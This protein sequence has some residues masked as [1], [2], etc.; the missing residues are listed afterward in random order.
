MYQYPI[1]RASALQ[2]F[3]AIVGVATTTAILLLLRQQLNTPVVALLYMLPVLG[4]TVR[5][6]L[7]SGIIA[8]AC[9]FLAF[10]FFFLSPYHT[11]VV[12]QGQDVIV[13]FVFLLIAIVIS[14]LVGRVK[15]SLAHAQAREQEVIQ[16]YK[17]SVELSGA[18][19]PEEVGKILASHLQDI[20]APANIQ[21][22]LNSIGE[23]QSVDIRQ[24]DGTP[25][26]H[27]PDC[28]AALVSRRGRLGEIRL[29]KG[30]G[31]F[32]EAE[33]R[34]LHVL[35]GQGTLALERV[36]LAEIE[37]RAIIL[38][39][40]DHLKSALL[41]SVSHE[42]RTPL[43]TIKAAATSLRSGT[44][45]WNTEARDD[46]LAALEEEADRLNQFV[47]ELLNMSRIEVGALKLQRQWNILAEIVDTSVMQMRT[48]LCEHQL[49]I[50][51]SEDLPLIPI[52][53][54]LLQQV[55]TNLL[56]N[57]LKYAPTNTLIRLTAHTQHASSMLIQIT[58]QGPPVQPEHLDHIFDKFH[59]VTA[60]DQIPGTGLGLSICKGIIEAHGGHIWAEN[61]PDGFAFK[62]VLPLIVEGMSSPK[63]PTDS[64]QT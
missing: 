13:L 6:G 62:F 19:H 41:S 32:G 51:V 56:S 48:S 27:T 12:H 40:S 43:V 34:L 46:L 63:M 59:R 47:G 61:L 36:A 35:A 15:T 58:N 26:A 9:S 24:P 14:Q 33:N 16:L 2:T 52:D 57:C 31:V 30:D 39:E 53:P 8:S 42:L 21:I 44:V 23:G 3:V 54:V 28:I 45:G 11:L 18:R 37:T 1:L 10:N 4:S 50:E 38:E 17:L 5:W 7:G 60:A 55:F 64:E 22:V 29:W 20:F 49:E 25:P